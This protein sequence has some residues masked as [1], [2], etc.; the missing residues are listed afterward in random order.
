MGT[1]FKGQNEELTSGGLIV[2]AL[3][4]AQ[5]IV[6]CEVVENAPVLLDASFR[7]LTPIK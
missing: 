4:K 6:N 5:N 7:F 1:H 2:M 3:R